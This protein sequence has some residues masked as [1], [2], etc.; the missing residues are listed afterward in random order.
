LG[1]FDSL[2]AVPIEQ[3]RGA[4]RGSGLDTGHPLDGLLE[5]FGWHGKRFDG[6][7][8]VHPLV[9]DHGSGLFSVKPGASAAGVG[10]AV[11]AVAAPPGLG[12]DV[13]PGWPCGVDEEAAGA[14]GDEC[15]PGRR[16]GDDV[17]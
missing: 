4:W 5:G 3:M 7:E 16:D 9:F 17:L 8:E 12:V 15:V 11:R 10:G 1:L 14:A 2:P 13:R 6:P